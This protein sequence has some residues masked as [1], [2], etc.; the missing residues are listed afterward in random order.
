MINESSPLL[1]ETRRKRF[2]SKGV[3]LL[4]LGK[5]IRMDILTEI[6]FLISRVNKVEEEDDGKRI[7]VLLHR[8]CDA[9]RFKN[10]L[11]V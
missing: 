11:G 4:Y 3:Q 1:D 2:H 7:R 10:N 9:L 6:A 5:R 8:G